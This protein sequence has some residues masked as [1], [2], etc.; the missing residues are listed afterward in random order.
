MKRLSRAARTILFSLFLAVAAPWLSMPASA[1]S[2][3]VPWNEEFAYLTGM[4]AY[5]YGFPAILYASLRWQWI[6]SGQGPVQMAV[7]QYWHS[8]Q[9]SDPNLQYGGS[10]NRETP[11]SLAFL[12]LGREPVVLT[13][14]PNPERRYYTLQLIDFYSDTIG[15]VGLRATNNVPGDYL[16]AG[17][18]W[19]GKPP[20][21]IKGVI[22]SWTPWALV[23]G[24]TYA[25]P[26]EEDLAKMRKFQDGYGITPLSAYGKPGASVPARKDVLDPAPKSDPLGA[27]KTMNAAMKE[28]P[29]PARDAALMRQFAL[30]GLGPLAKGDIEALDPAVK[31]G[32]TRAIV[33]GQ[34][35]LGRVAKAGGSI[36]DATRVRNNWFYGA[37]NWGRTAESA[38]FL[39]RAG[40][41]AFSGV[42]EHR[43]QETVKLRTFVDAE[44]EPLDG[45]NRYE[46]RFEKKDIPE[47]HSFW[48]VTLYDE[49]FN[50]VYNE[51]GRYSFGDK[52]P[53]L[54]HADDGSLTIYIQPDA[55]EG[56]K[57]ANW[58]PSP[59]GKP[60]NLF[61]RAYLP[62]KALLDQS[63]VAP[64]VR[65]VGGGQ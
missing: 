21:G 6:E 10:P 56:D 7:N 44:G 63:Y 17:P 38:D 5:I 8:R 18:N 1:A 60:F 52:V 2:E 29:P 16:V 59:R 43:I 22:R 14:P 65:K 48:S 32:L 27:F 47:A 25:D 42:T 15:Y 34:A 54:R 33:D 24:R 40:T 20:K 13:V 41:Q 62:G 4:Q 37:S 19:R 12:D 26:T 50:L 51:A 53:G 3:P 30:V 57:A 58:L 39:A 46:I 35:L 9:P 23:A 55:P 45:R 31:R 28:N 49:K 36:T 11:Y 64:P 61:L